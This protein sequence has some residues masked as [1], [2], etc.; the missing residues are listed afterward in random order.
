MEIRPP[1]FLVRGWSQELN[2]SA[3]C[4]GDA[5]IAPTAAQT[6]GR[7]LP[8]ERPRR[9]SNPRPPT[10]KSCALPTELVGRVARVQ[11]SD[12]GHLRRERRD[13][14]RDVADL[15]Q[16]LAPRRALGIEAH[17]EERDRSE[18]CLQ[19]AVE[20]HLALRLADALDDAHLNTLVGS[21]RR[22]VVPQLRARRRRPRAGAA[23]PPRM[24]RPGPRGHRDRGT[25][26]LSS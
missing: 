18:S 11:A 17:R 3:R 15:S 22:W 8:P 9:E 12:F 26:R 13:G 6:D 14:D 25:R 7:N 21:L 23:P 5:L 1:G 4:S 20:L 24:G 16:P 19:R 2:G 10:C